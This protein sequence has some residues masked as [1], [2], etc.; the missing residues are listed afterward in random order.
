MR[1]TGP[2]RS[3]SSHTPWKLV[4]TCSPITALLTH[5]CSAARGQPPSPT[6]WHLQHLGVGDVT[7]IIPSPL[8]VLC[9]GSDFAIVCSPWRNLLPDLDASTLSG[10]PGSSGTGLCCTQESDPQ[11]GHTEASFAF[12]LAIPGPT[13][14]EGLHGRLL[15]V[16]RL[17]QIQGYCRV[18]SAREKSLICE[19]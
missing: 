10:L 12:S 13:L 19:T 9:Q 4:T 14:M 3:P 15:R 5:R 18:D 6:S 16:S 7:G 1:I 17:I 8:V 11:Y 2:L